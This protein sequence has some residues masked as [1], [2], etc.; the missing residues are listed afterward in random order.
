MRKKQIFD[1]MLALA[2]MVAFVLTFFGAA[3]LLNENPRGVIEVGCAF[4]IAIP[5]IILTNREEKA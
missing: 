1:G 2:M 5:V 3:E 4:V